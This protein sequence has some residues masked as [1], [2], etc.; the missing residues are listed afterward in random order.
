MS[1][2]S[3]LNPIRNC[4][5]KFK[6]SKEWD[7]LKSHESIKNVRLCEECKSLV[8]FV[9]NEEELA[10]RIW[11]NDCV[12][13]P[14]ELGRKIFDKQIIKSASKPSMGSVRLKK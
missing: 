1:N 6:C 12:A 7:S 14:A 4:E 8:H 13:I 5:F 10:F 11:R 3:E 2:E 9:Q